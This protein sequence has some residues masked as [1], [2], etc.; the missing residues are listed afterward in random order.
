[1]TELIGEEILDEFD[2][3]NQARLSHYTIE[4]PKESGS[5]VEVVQPSPKLDAPDSPNS[6]SDVPTSRTMRSIAIARM[7]KKGA[8]G[9]SKRQNSGPF[10]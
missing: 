6:T 8:K 7:T 5:D 1:M 10:W 4:K 2:T 9:G 3:E